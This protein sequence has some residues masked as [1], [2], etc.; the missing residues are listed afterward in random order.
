M[1]KYIANQFPV[2]QKSQIPKWYKRNAINGDLYH[3]WRISSNYYHEKNEIRNKF[4]TAG[5]PMIFINTVINA[6]E[7]KESNDT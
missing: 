6:F 2:Q 5:Y 3:S 7:S 1:M 4:S